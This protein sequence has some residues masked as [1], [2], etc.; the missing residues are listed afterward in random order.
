[1]RYL[2]NKIYSS[3]KNKSFK[4]EVLRDASLASL[5]NL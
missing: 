1:M 4:G 5:A 2:A 3:F